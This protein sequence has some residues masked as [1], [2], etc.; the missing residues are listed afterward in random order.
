MSRT[1]FIGDVHGCLDELQDLLRAVRVDRGDRL[2][3][4]GDL[5][6]KGPDSLGV[7]DWARTTPNL[8]CVLGNHEWRLLERR[9]SGIPSGRASDVA[10][11]ISLGRRAGEVLDWFADKPLVI[12]EGGWM[13]VHAGIDA[14]LPLAAQPV[15]TLVDVRCL[16]DGHTPWYEHYRDPRLIVY[17]HW[18]KPEP[19]VRTN[20]IGLDTG[21][22]Y[23]GFLTALILPE[24][25]LVQ[26][27]ARRVY[28]K[29]E[30][31]AVPAG[32]R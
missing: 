11:M 2:I 30:G 6:G 10:T 32:S 19:V 12:D 8:E 16:D 27:A 22:V 24:R 18:A 13:A 17:G 7:F 9:R 26:V 28:K 1:I 3:S 5:I 23:G 29:K 15:S 21:C 14:R 20:S 31:W 25:R 4:V